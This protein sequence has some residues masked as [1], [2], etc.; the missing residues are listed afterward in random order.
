MNAQNIRTHLGRIADAIDR[1]GLTT[2]SIRDLIADTDANVAAIRTAYDDLVAALDAD[3][4]AA[5]DAIAA[6]PS[7]FAEVCATVAQARTNAEQARDLRQRA[8]ASVYR[9][10]V[11]RLAVVW[12][13][14]LEAATVAAHDRALA[15]LEKLAPKIDG[16][17]DDEQAVA[18]GAKVAADWARAATLVDQR[19]AAMR[20]RF[21]V[22]QLLGLPAEQA[23]DHEDRSYR[24]PDLLPRYHPRDRDRPRHRIPE[25]LAAIDAGAEPALV[26]DLAGPLGG[27]G[28]DP[29]EVP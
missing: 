6:T 28:D 11:S 12:P 15:E 2:A 17:A 7:V 24:R 14:E 13:D 27:V 10:A 29:P 26:L 20:V 16:I 19:D 4:R 23:H 8:I 22:A 25:L 18:A 3:V 21:E 1:L 5:G 9:Q